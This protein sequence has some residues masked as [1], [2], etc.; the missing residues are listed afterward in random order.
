[1][2]LFGREMQQNVQRVNAYAQLLFCSL[3]LLFG[4]VPIA[5]ASVVCLSPKTKQNFASIQ[6]FHSTRLV[7]PPLNTV[8][9]YF[10]LVVIR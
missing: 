2:L 8:K 4:E 10:L 7:K 6:E 9:L 3:N 5:I 1:M